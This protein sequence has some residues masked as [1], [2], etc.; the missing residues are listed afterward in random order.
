MTHEKSEDLLFLAELLL[1]MCAITPKTFDDIYE[2]SYPYDYDDHEVNWDITPD[3]YD[4]DIFR[5][6]RK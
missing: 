5:H 2:R 1:K 6:D 4:H 3:F